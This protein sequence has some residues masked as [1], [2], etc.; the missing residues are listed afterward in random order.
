VLNFIA[1][2]IASIAIVMAVVG[3]TVFLILRLVP[4]DPIAI[5][6][7]DNASQEQI[8]AIRK[9]VGLDDPLPVQFWR[10]AGAV[11]RGDFGISIF[12]GA[13]VL[14]LITERLEPTISLTLVTLF[15]AVPIAVAA[16]ITAAARAG[17]AAD[18]TLMAL[19]VVGFSV[20]GFVVGYL[21][22]YVFAITLKWLP[23][24]GYVP[25][26]DGVWPWLQRLILPAA[27]LGFAYVALI[28]RITRTAMLDVL[29]EDY[30]RTAK[31]KGVAPTPTL[32]HHALKNAGVPIVTIIGIGLAVLIGGAIVTETVFNLPGVGRLVVDAIQKR[33]YPVIQG[34]TL[35]LSAT[36]V[37]VNLLIDLTYTLIDPRVR[38]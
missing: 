1:R 21:L 25:I 26:A 8:D 6:A 38:Y 4:G 29:N 28:A 10:W 13:P 3:V 30:I 7:G 31:A 27:T 5:L 20:P 14:Q 34:I 2:R 11:L 18:R 12:S 16:G 23:V 9:S 33:D 35:L 24:Q 15:V 32:F 17:S 22:I 19:S 36:Y 37:L